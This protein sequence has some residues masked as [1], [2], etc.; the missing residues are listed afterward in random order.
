MK[1]F[2]TAIFST[3]LVC[4]PALA[5][6]HVAD[7][8][9]FSQPLASLNSEQRLDFA[10]GRGFFRRLWVSAPASTR[11]ADG[12]GPLYDAR[13]C[14][15]CHP[16][17][18]RGRG[19][20][21]TGAGAMALVLRIDIPPQDAHQE[22]LLATHRINNV[23]EPTYG[24]QLQRFAIPGHQAEQR[25][26]VDYLEAALTLD[27]G[28]SVRLRRPTYRVAG[29]GY[30]PLHPQA[31]M[32]PRIAPRLVGLGLL[33]AIPE[34]D[35]L[36][37][38]DPH[39]RDGDGISGRANRVWSETAGRKVVGRFGH[40]AGMPDLDQQS[41]AAFATDLGL[42]V[43]MFP[44]A[45]GDCTERQPRCLAAPNGNSARY[46]DLEAH[47][48]V[49]DL[50][51][52][53]VSHLA[54]PARRDSAA[55]DVIA[56]EQIFMRLGCQKCHTPAYHTGDHTLSPATHH[57]DIAPYSD[58]LLHDM[59]EALADNRPEG[60]ADGREWRTAPLWGIGLTAKVSGHANF[61][62]DGRARSLLEAILWH[63]GE[64]HAQRDAVIALDRRSR[65]QLLAFIGSL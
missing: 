52:A 14:M 36:D 22:E 26:S 46:D 28:S 48:Q 18:G 45:A 24:L 60:I 37:Q 21:Q 58:L 44:S 20:A 50:V 39:D 64:A 27:D 3:A 5:M 13:S 53:Y 4:V 57:R 61:L 62:H 65:E 35:I 34:Q 59:G 47:Q 9:L 41:Q 40:K 30:G 7:T 25:L 1:Y 43:P 29:L 12:L 23:P 11:A 32:S 17:N 49:T 6:Q 51:R 16:N 42:S 2:T 54:V 63:G 8:S 31:R 56:G 55:P 10:V 38:A 19:P 15:A 33:E